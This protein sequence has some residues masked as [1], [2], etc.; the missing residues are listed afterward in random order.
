MK[1]ICLDPGHGGE[2]PGAV[3]SGLKEKDITLK[4]VKAAVQ[5]LEE[6]FELI[7]TRENDSTIP[8]FKRVLK[9]NTH[10][11]DIFISIHCNADLDSD[12]P[13]DPEAK[14]EEIWVF[15]G[16][17]QSKKL[18]QS[19]A[20][21]VD[22]VFPKEPFRGIK[23]TEKLYVLKHTQMPA[24]LI[25]V[26]FIDKSTSEETFTDQDCIDRIGYFIAEGIHE[27]FHTNP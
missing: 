9:A 22:L 23:E 5:Y 21:W 10:D 12:L 3:Y 24:C 27:Y 4:I 26:G 2:D 1:R 6:D 7:L 25:E 14:G 15:K 18:A 19:L 17:E 8:L 16:A 11:A 20:D 13:G